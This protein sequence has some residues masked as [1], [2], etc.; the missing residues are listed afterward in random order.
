MQN[1]VEADSKSKDLRP[2]PRAPSNRPEEA[3]L[4]FGPVQRWLIEAEE[5][6]T[7]LILQLGQGVLATRNVNL[8]PVAGSPAALTE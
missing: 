2:P 1:V 3:T 6:E 4:F 5:P 7:M 8:A